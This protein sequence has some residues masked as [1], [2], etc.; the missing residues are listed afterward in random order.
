VRVWGESVKVVQSSMKF[1]FGSAPTNHWHNTSVIELLRTENNDATTDAEMLTKSQSLCSELEIVIQKTNGTY[2]KVMKRKPINFFNI[3]TRL[4]VTLTFGKDESHVLKR[5]RWAFAMV[6]GL[7]HGIYQL[8][9]NF[10]GKVS[11]RGLSVLEVRSGK[12]LSKKEGAR[13]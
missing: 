1:F 13:D 10:H 6:V 4:L 9:R 3:A 11:T 5:D 2:E 8:V 12:V 7:A